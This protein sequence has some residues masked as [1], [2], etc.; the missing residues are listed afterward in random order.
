MFPPISENSIDRLINCFS[1]SNH[2][3]M[4][5]LNLY[6]NLSRRGGL[7]WLGYLPYTQVI[8]GSN[9]IPSMLIIGLPIMCYREK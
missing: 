2:F 3:Y 1:I 7:D 5:G 6:E 4:Y 9:P 8:M